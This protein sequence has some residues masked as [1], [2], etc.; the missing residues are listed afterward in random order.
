M[1]HTL[2]SFNVSGVIKRNIRGP[3]GSR[4]ILLTL[5]GKEHEFKNKADVKTVGTPDLRINVVKRVFDNLEGAQGL[6]LKGNSV[7]IQGRIHGKK[8]I[9]QGRPFYTTELRAENIRPGRVVENDFLIGGKLMALDPRGSGAIMAFVKSSKLKE[10][11]IGADE[12]G[13]RFNTPIVPV[14]INRQEI[15]RVVKSFKDIEIDKHLYPWQRLYIESSERTAIAEHLFITKEQESLFATLKK[16][17]ENPS[18]EIRPAFEKFM[19]KRYRVAT[20]EQIQ[21]MGLIHAQ[22]SSDIFCKGYITSTKRRMNENNY[23]SAEL[24]CNS[25]SKVVY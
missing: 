25:V 5:S 21:F 22:E 24:Q 3:G 12:T 1:S 7:F 10:T 17:K 14:K 23:F 8:I 15:S 11:E 2:S 6:L 16:N 13:I 20:K 4:I 18:V 19:I 9:Y